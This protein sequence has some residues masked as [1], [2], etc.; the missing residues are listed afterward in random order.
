[1]ARILVIDDDLDLLQMTRLMLQRGGH[2]VIVTADGADGITKARQLHPDLAIVD[3]MMPGMNGFQVTRRLR[4]DPATADIVI[5][6]LTARAQPVDRD[7]AMSAKADDYMSKPVAPPELLKKVDEM[8]NKGARLS[9]PSHFALTTFSLRGGV[10]VTTLCVNLGLMFQQA[11]AKTCVVDLSMRSGHVGTQF[12][13]QSKT[14]WLDLLPQSNV[15][16]METVERVMLKHST[17]LLVL[18]APFL[19]PVQ[20]I[21]GEALAKLLTLLKSALDIIV[22]DTSGTVDI[23]TRVALAV[24]DQVLVVTAPEVAA[25]Q[26]TAASL[27]LLNSFKVPDDKIKL[28]SNQVMPRPGLT[29]PAIEK[30]LGRPIQASI[31]YDEAQ[32]QALGQGT[33]LAQSYPDA[34]LPATLKQVVDAVL[35]PA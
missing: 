6:I 33:P 29:S 16:S 20:P 25:L 26:T 17:G 28:I 24:A 13:L 4:E 12:R 23:T 32:A 35:Q 3:V 5:L 1:M 14:S 9:M 8:L 11:G 2:E 19:P 10:G 30:A 34:P 22:I 31:P 21:N 7:A 15:F 18:P 27:R